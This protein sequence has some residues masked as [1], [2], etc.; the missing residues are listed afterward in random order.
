[1]ELTGKTFLAV[2]G[3]KD[4]VEFGVL[5]SFAYKVMIMIVITT[6]QCSTSQMYFYGICWYMY[7]TCIVLEIQGV[8]VNPTFDLQI[9]DETEIVVATTRPET[10][11]GDVAIAVHPQDPRYTGLIGKKAKHPFVDREL[12]VVADDFVDREFGTGRLCCIF[13]KASS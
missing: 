9:D 11:L 7:F 8:E 1:M 12:P 4:K 3:Y 6:E 5:T 13:S 2:P 10:M